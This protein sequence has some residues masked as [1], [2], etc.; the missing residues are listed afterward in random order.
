[1][2]NVS[3]QVG[4]YRCFRPDLRVWVGNID[5]TPPDPMVAVPIPRKHHSDG[6]RVMDNHEV[7][8][9]LTALAVLL[10]RLHK[11]IEVFLPG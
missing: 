11:D 4:A 8:V 6:L 10:R 1:M 3:K 5:M 2:W 9:E 7:F